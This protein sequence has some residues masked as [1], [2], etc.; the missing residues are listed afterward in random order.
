MSPVTTKRSADRAS[1]S[2]STASKQGT[3]PWVSLTTAIRSIRGEY[4]RRP[5]RQLERSAREATREATRE[6]RG[7]VMPR[8]VATGCGCSV[9]TRSGARC[10][11]PDCDQ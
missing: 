6:V 7:R 8:R 9:S 1:G 5:G 11:L 4:A 2:A 10:S 3:T